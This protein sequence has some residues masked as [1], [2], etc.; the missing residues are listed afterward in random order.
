MDASRLLSR[1]SAK[2]VNDC[3][4]FGID[5]RRLTAGRSDGMKDTSKLGNRN[6]VV[7]IADSSRHWLAR[8]LHPDTRI[9]LGYI[10]FWRRKG[11]I[12]VTN[13]DAQLARR[14]LNMGGGDKQYK[15][16]LAGGHGEG[17]KAAAVV[18]LREGYQFRYEASGCYWRFHT[19]KSDVDPEQL[20]CELKPMRPKPLQ[21]T[22]K[23]YEDKFGNGTPREE[24]S[25]IHLDVAVKLGNVYESKNHH[26]ESI[27]EETFR[28]LIPVSL[29][30]M[31]PTT[32]ITTP[33][34]ELI[35]DE[36]FKDTTYLKRLLV[37]GN[38]GMTRYKYGY[39]FY[40]GTI[41]RDRRR[42]P[43]TRAD[44]CRG[45]R[46]WESVIEQQQ[47]YLG[48]YIA[49]MEDT[50]TSWADVYLAKDYVTKALAE[51][52]SRFYFDKDVNGEVF[53][54]DMRTSDKV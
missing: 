32:V 48:D 27:D 47:Q 52:V 14:S 13:F 42:L 24:T 44:A 6:F 45:A 26:G 8:A 16:Y 40:D 46:I 30:L 31:A 23:E 36:A 38:P 22:R 53:Y 35:V 15:D 4:L 20:Y 12:E 25:F 18:A 5:K 41:D 34:G 11:M 49:M 51:K 7:E 19:G 43:N 28:E 39:H 29:D 33:Y 9:L 2:L 3:K 10:R 50:N 17:Y 54:H 21:K 1:D 37:E